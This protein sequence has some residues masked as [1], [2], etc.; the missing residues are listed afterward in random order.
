MEN[1]KRSLPSNSDKEKERDPEN[2][3]IVPPF[4]HINSYTMENNDNILP[5]LT[6][7]EIR[8][9]DLFD[10]NPTPTKIYDELNQVLGE[11]Q[12]AKHRD[13]TENA[14]AGPSNQ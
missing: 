9:L 4:F 7:E 2:I 12:N 5:P 10:I 13:L 1:C 11:A 8:N 6:I 3:I 14:D